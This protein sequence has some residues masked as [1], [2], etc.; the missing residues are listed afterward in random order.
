M[1]HLDGSTDSGSFS[2]R[3]YFSLVQ[4]VSTNH[5][6]GL[7]VYVKEKIHFAQGLYLENSADSYSCFELALLHSVSYFFFLSQ[8]LSPSL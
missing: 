5:M 2:V 8:S 7:T 4:K 6:H 3:G 1:R